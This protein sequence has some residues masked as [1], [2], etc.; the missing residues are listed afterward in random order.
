MG[1]VWL[2]FVFLWVPAIHGQT[3]S[4][5][6]YGGSGSDS[7]NGVAVDSSGNIWTVGATT[8]FDLPLLNPSQAANTGTQLV[9][10][11]DAGL[12]WKPLVNL[13]A[14]AS[15]ISGPLQIAVESHQ[16]GGRLCREWPDGL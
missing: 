4:D 11:P 6:I 3:L 10:S 12:T 13:P 5:R 16:P 7:I 14:A 2:L 9:Y 15:P 8:S 1:R